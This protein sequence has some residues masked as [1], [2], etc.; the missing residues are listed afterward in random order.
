MDG[1]TPGQVSGGQA[2]AGAGAD[3][4]AA[5]ARPLTLAE[6]KSRLLEEEPGRAGIV[7]DWIRRNPGG[8]ALAA[9]GASLVLALS[10]RIRRIAFPLL[11]LA[12]R[13]SIL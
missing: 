5:R 4:L 3:A 1:E 12:A 8:A 7:T 11:T 2:D 10:P 6:A 9:V 13:K